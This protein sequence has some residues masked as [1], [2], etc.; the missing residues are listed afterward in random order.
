MIPQDKTH[1]V[2]HALH[3]A[4]GAVE[5]EDIRPMPA[6]LGSDLAFRIV[7]KGSPFLLKI[8][9]RIDERNDP[10]RIFPAM[11]A[12]AEAGLSPRVWHANVENGISITDF[13]ETV[14]L[15]ISEA[16]VRIPDALRTLHA[17]PPFPKTFNYVTAHNGFIWRL[18]TSNLLPGNEVEETFTQ[19][20]KVCAVYPRLE[21]DMV[22]SHMDLKPENILFD[23]RR[24]WLVDWQAAFLNDRYFDLAVAANF[25]LTNDAAE[26]VYL[27]RYFD[28]PPGEYQLARFFLMRQAMHMFYAAVFLLL[29]SAGKPVNQSEEL[30]A[31]QDFHQRIWAGQ[32][33]LADNRMKTVYGRVHWRQLVENLRKPRLNEALTIVSNRHA[34]PEA[35]RLL[36][37][38]APTPRPTCA[39][40]PGAA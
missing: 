39:P 34:S 33:N 25:V 6:G 19:Y 3:D 4:F 38:A 8:M 14:P 20:E 9:T 5:I 18:R 32:V 12:A 16:L 2:S 35:T 30:P 10:R 7:V 29:G 26:S 27:Q 23:G 36:P 37:S 13:I 40:P 21:S 22:S 31:F 1:A 28:Q 15:P 17:L 11:Q 24:L